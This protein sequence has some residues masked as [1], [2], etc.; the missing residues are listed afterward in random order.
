MRTLAWHSPGAALALSVQR[1]IYSNGFRS[2]SKV[3]IN[4]VTVG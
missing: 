2:P 4:S 1:K 3:G